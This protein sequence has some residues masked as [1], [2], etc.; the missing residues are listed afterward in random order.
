MKKKKKNEKN[1]SERNAR[2]MKQSFGITLTRH[3]FRQ[4]EASST[5]AAFLCTISRQQ[6]SDA[7]KKKKKKKLS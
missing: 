1:L 6:Q 2:W 7:R 5:S 3:S 4:C